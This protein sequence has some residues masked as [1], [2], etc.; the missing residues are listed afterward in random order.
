MFNFFLARVCFLKGDSATAVLLLTSCSV[1]DPN[2][3]AFGR[4]VFGLS[5]TFIINQLKDENFNNECLKNVLDH[6]EFL[7]KSNRLLEA[8]AILPNLESS[9]HCCLLAGI[10]SYKSGLLKQAII[11]F[12]EALT[13]DPTLDAA[14]DLTVKAQNFIHLMEGASHQMSLN[15]YGVAT[16]MLTLALQ[17]DTENKRVIAGIFLQRAFCKLNMGKQD[18]AFQDYLMFEAYEKESEK[19]E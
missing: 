12:G 11:K 8:E 13:A 15:R 2:N 18:E 19:F 7:I 9:A 17:I 10:L 1:V 6:V 4:K 16:E 5:K 3:L 14:K